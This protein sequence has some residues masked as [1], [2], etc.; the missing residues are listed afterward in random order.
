MSL[1]NILGDSRYVTPLR[2]VLKLSFKVTFHLIKLY[3][4]TSDG[5]L[6]FIIKLKNRHFKWTDLSNPLGVIQY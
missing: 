2:N 5:I 4:L 1:K 6:V 3:L